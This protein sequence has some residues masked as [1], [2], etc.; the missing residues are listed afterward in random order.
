MNPALL[1]GSFADDPLDTPTAWVLGIVSIVVCLGL[2]VG[3][4]VILVCGNPEQTEPRPRELRCGMRGCIRPATHVSV[5]PDGTRVYTCPGDAD[6]LA[7]CRWKTLP[8]GGI[9]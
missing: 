8:L 7:H 4:A 5:H 9:R 1:L 2:L 3:I 6:V